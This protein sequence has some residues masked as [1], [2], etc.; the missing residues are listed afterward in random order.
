MKSKGV[1][2]LLTRILNSTSEI[3][4]TDY[5]K[6]YGVFAQVKVLRRR[7]KLRV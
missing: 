4:C 5:F 1:G 6:N 3:T 7:V 2:G